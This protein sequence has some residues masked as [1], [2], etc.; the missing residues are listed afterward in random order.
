[1]VN[2]RG[3][4][5]VDSCTYVSGLNLL[6][7]PLRVQSIL[8][9]FDSANTCYVQTKKNRHGERYTWKIIN[10]CYVCVAELAHAQGSD[11]RV[12]KISK[13]TTLR[14]S[15]KVIRRFQIRF[16]D[17]CHFFGTVTSGDIAIV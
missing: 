11:S 12:S 14:F 16:A 17:L 7:R 3:H 10:L 2:H 13:I 5:S 9:T 6:T 4:S 15:V 1:M 8:V